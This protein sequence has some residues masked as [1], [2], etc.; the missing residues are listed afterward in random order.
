MSLHWAGRCRPHRLGSGS[1]LKRGM[2]GG[3]GCWPRSTSL[4]RFI[5]CMWLI[6]PGAN[7]GTS[8][9]AAN[10]GVQHPRQASATS[11]AKIF[12]TLLVSLVVAPLE[13]KLMAILPMRF[14][15]TDIIVVR[16]GLRLLN[17]CY[18]HPSLG[19]HGFGRSAQYPLPSPVPKKNCGFASITGEGTIGEVAGAAAA[20]WFTTVL[21]AACG[22]SAVREKDFP[23][24]SPVAKAAVIPPITAAQRS[25]RCRSTVGAFCADHVHG[26][27]HVWRYRLNLSASPCR[28]KCDPQHTESVKLSCA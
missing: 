22:R 14:L 13:R 18:S 6:M 19:V 2:T 23:V 21:I 5:C 17:P 25:M 15:T 20:D 3:V 8:W 26:S 9:A 1:A 27:L 11:R 24:S 28:R 7:A 12:R 16:S 4:K 10:C